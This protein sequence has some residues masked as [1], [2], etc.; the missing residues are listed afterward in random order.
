MTG[1][2]TWRVGLIAAVGLAAAISAGP[3]APAASADPAGLVN[4][5]NGSLGPGFPMVSAALPF[6]LIQPGPDTALPD[7]SQDPV[8]YDGYSYQDPDIRGFSLTHFDGAGIQ[9][10][11]DVPFM[12]TTGAVNASDPAG[13][14]SPYDHATEVAQPG[15]YA[16]SLERWQTRVELTS[17][18]RA[19]MMRFTFPATSQA[20]LLAEAS[21]SI[22]GTHTGSVSVVGDDELQ[23]HVKSDV[24]YTVYFDAIF[25]RPFTGTG[26][27]P[28]GEY[29]SFNTTSDPTVT[30]RVGISYVDQAGAANN[31]ATEIPATRSFDD[32]RGAARA[33]WD[34]RLGSITI[35]GGS[36][37]DQ[38][39]FY[40]NLYRSLLMP[41]VFDDADGR[42]LGM[43]GQVHQVAAGHHQYTA[44]SLWDTYRSQMPLLELIAPHVAGDVLAS[45]LTDAGQNHGV[46]PRWVQANIDRGIMAGDSGSAVLADGAAE[47][48]LGAAGAR[49]A[50]SLLV[51]QAT[52]LPPVWPREHLDAY[53]KYGY[54]PYDIDDIGPSVTEEYN[55]DDYAVAQLAQALGDTSDAAALGARSDYWQHL[56]NPANHFIQ[57]RNSDGSWASP[58]HS[59][60]PGFS[61]LDT[62]ALPLPY[63]PDFQDGYQEATG[64]QDLWGVPHDVAGLAQAI[65][66]TQ[67]TL[68][69]LDRFFSTA[70]NQPLAPAV[71]LAQQEISF[72]GVYYVGNQYT[73][74]NEPDL[75]APW[76][77]DWLGQPW[78][79]QK[80]ARAESE[81]YNQTPQ[82]LP[83]NDDTG[84]MGAWYVLQALG[85][86]H[87][88][89]G[90]DAWEL[91]S[92]EFPL[93]VVR[94]GGHRLVIEAPGASRLRPYVHGVA[95]GRAPVNRTYLTSCQL[96]AGGRLHFSLGATPDRSWGTGPD[97]APPSASAPSADADACA[98]QLAAG[99]AP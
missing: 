76:Y 86:Y 8:N 38:K 66:G 67:V 35:T 51:A 77:Y 92:P 99:S 62:S 85:V 97:A 52:T 47:G 41:S 53:L 73:P 80:V 21:Q 34:K 25:D 42:Y 94:E 44:L 88:A 74:V 45:L 16:V 12:P 83:G 50:L 24:G 19:A 6:G 91:S 79:T 61:G 10:A 81:T 2:R 64:W 75:W 68:H 36:R 23:G 32:V 15:Y 56:V 26:A 40:D 37:G 63:S 4:T 98:A 58:A 22:N 82:G 87:A 93:A 48:L 29:V 70:L 18:L 72:F 39:T 43:D 3:L 95:L 65:G 71:P 84:E 9:I 69:R 30:M 59:S 90:V 57:P 89:P 46:I 55:T 33:A 60:N 14:A 20:N 54:V 96:F 31:L 7:G 27:L 28:G 78:K 49:Q 11:G 1:G 5:L 17:T 13:N